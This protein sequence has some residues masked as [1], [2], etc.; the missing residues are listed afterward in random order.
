M[1]S[2]RVL[3]QSAAALV[4]LSLAGPVAA[5]SAGPMPVVA[6]FSILGDMV[7]RMGGK[8]I[9]LTTLVGPD[10]KV[11]AKDGGDGGSGSRP[12]M[13]DARIEREQGVLLVT[14]SLLASA[15]RLQQLLDWCGD[16]FDWVSDLIAR[17]PG[18]QKVWK[19]VK[20]NQ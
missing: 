14:Y 9:A 17:S 3:L 16:G 20:I 13:A 12:A 4:A 15:G 5:Q 10:G 7:Q 1:K 2:R 19:C 18:A 11:L 6:R 8:H